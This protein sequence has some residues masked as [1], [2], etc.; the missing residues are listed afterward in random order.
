VIKAGKQGAWF[1]DES[2]RGFCP[3]FPATEIDPVGAGDAFCAGVLSGLLEGLTLAAA[4]S[5]GAALGAFSVSTLG[6]YAGLPDRAQLEAFMESK[7]VH[8]R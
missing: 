3:S 5:R 4:V 7:A 6:D 1:A 2:S 8:G